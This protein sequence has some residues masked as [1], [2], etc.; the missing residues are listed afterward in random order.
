MPA[1]QGTIDILQLLLAG[2][3]E[4]G[5]NFADNLGIN[6]V[7]GQD[8]AR[9]RE[10]FQTGR[11]VDAVAENIAVFDPDVAQIDADAEFYHAAG[12]IGAG[13]GIVFRH[14]FLKGHGAG[15]R[16]DDRGEFRQGPVTHH[17]RDAAI[18]FLDAGI[19][20]VPPD[21]AQ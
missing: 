19:E 5:V 11:D 12:M 7:R 6:A 14:A 18:E 20:I 10:T 9:R 17:F 2:I 21:V 16:I 8:A 15:D 13:A 4:H 1:P 3:R